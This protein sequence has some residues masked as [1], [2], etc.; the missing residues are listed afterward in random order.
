MK[1]I[2]YIPR[3]EQFSKSNDSPN[4]PNRE[5]F[6]LFSCVSAISAHLFHRINGPADFI[7]MLLGEGLRV[8]IELDTATPHARCV[9][10]PINILAL[11]VVSQSVPT[12][13]VGHGCTLSTS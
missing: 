3:M 1:R 12:A 9:P 4:A 5:V 6:V 11:G 2:Y 8:I 7:L 10:Q 13:A